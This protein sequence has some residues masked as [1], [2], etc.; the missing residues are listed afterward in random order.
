MNARR[1]AFLIG[2]V[3]LAA[4][5]AGAF[6]DTTQFLRSYLWAYWFWIGAAIGCGQLLMLYHLVGGAWGFVIQRVLEAALRTLPAMFV[7]AIPLV[8]GIPRLYSYANPHLVAADRALAHKAVYLNMPAVIVRLAIYFAI[9]GLIGYLFNRWSRRQDETEDY[10]YHR[11]RVRLSAPGIILFSFAS[12]FAVVDWIMALEPDWYSTMF[13]GFYL[14]GQVLTALAVAIL[15]LYYV[16]GEEPLRSLAAR[17]TYHDLGNLLWAFVIL[18]AYVEISQL[19]IT[20]SGNLPKEIVWYLHRTRGNWAWIT[21]FLALFHFGV[22]FFIL[23]GRKNKQ[24]PRRLAWIAGFIV[25]VHCIEQYWNVEPAFHPDIFVSW[26]DFAAPI[27]LGGLWVGLFLTQLA[28]RPLVPEHDP[29][30]EEALE[31][32]A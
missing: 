21:T 9:F 16:S 20:W 17:K 32:A 19:I 10:R 28:R 12:T 31:K 15:A 8:I 26:L 13:P 3:G 11:M 1:N 2:A 7:L 6:L 29:R 18:W 5:V 30:L 24:Q 4:C 14:V 23:L 25:V 27:G 22:P